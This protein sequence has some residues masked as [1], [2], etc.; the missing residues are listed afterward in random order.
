[1]DGGF[2]ADDD[3]F[4]VFGEIDPSFADD[5]VV[6]A[7]DASGPF[8]SSFVDNADTTGDAAAG[9]DTDTGDSGAFSSDT[10][11]GDATSS[12]IIIY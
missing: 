12:A 7:F 8:D 4:D 6:A 11:T 5:D 9:V 3:G 2:D 10:D 1:V